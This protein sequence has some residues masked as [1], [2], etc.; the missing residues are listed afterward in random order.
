MGVQRKKHK[1]RQSFEK[2]WSVKERKDKKEKKEQKTE[3]KYMDDVEQKVVYPT[4]GPFL[5]VGLRCSRELDLSAEGTSS[6][7]GDE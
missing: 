7:S 3:E 6:S 2:I 4:T 5:V 1:V